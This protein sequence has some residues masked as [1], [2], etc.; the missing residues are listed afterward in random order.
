MNSIKPNFKVPLKYHR[1]FVLIVDHSRHE[2]EVS[3]SGFQ[4]KSDGV[5]FQNEHCIIMD[6]IQESIMQVRM[7]IGHP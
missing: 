3:C 6:W 1:H 2:I 5:L 7:E 4:L